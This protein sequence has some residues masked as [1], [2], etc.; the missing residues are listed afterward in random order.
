MRLLLR[1]E[2]VKLLRAKRTWIAVILLLAFVLFLHLQSMRVARGYLNDTHSLSHILE[3]PSRITCGNTACTPAARTEI[4]Q[5]LR[6]TLTSDERQLQIARRAFSPGA[7]PIVATGLFSTAVGAAAGLLVSTGS[8]GLEFDNRTLR[9][10]LPRRP[11]RTRFLCAK[12]TAGFLL[13]LGL[14][15]FAAVLIV[16]F[17]WA[18]ASRIGPGLGPTPTSSSA[19]GP[20]AILM[21]VAPVVVVGV[22]VAMG[23][24]FGVLM[25]SGLGAFV[26]T[27]AL[28]SIDRLAAISSKVAAPYT[29]SF[30]VWSLGTAFGRWVG[31]QVSVTNQ[32]WPQGFPRAARPPLEAFLFLMVVLLAGFGAALGCF[33]RQEIY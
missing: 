8:L 1:A 24:A 15:A 33:W 13:C 3:D 9:T 32:L 7:G 2:A 26:G 25:R 12:M 31:T 14:T 22:M 30:N 20:S 28:L 18:L 27:G 5:R 21:V 19:A 17:N 16:L 6:Q 10:L 23:S 29:L 4:E 11:S